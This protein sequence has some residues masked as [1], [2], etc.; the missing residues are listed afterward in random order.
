[1]LLIFNS[2]GIGELLFR[3]DIAEIVNPDGQCKPSYLIKPGVTKKGGM[4]GEPFERLLQ[5]LRENSG[6]EGYGL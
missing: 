3:S 6:F 5:R 1:M 2:T 4:F